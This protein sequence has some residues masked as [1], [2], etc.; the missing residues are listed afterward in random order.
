MLDNICEHLRPEGD[1]KGGTYFGATGC[2]KTYTMLFLSRLMMLRR[3]EELGNPTIVLIVDR[4]DLDNQA[5]E[6]FVT[7]KRFLHDENVRSIETRDDL[8]ETLRGRESGGVY[9]TTI[10]KFS[11]QMGLLSFSCCIWEP[12]IECFQV[13]CRLWRA[14]MPTCGLRRR[15]RPRKGEW[16]PAPFGKGRGLAG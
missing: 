1:G 9:I 2:G 10:Q 3:S 8:A 16:H 13:Q 14:G 6:L 11:E 12:N 5:S 4:E 7:A 15:M